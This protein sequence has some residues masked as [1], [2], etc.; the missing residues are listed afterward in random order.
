MGILSTPILGDLLKGVLGVVD[1]LHTSDEEKADIKF[2]ISQLAQSADLAQIAVN[3]EEAK[4]T[5]LFVSGW[6][7]SIG[8]VCSVAF[9]CNFVLFPMLTYVV[10]VIGEFTGRDIDIGQVPQFDLA[11]LMPVLLGML[12]LGTMRTY[13][14]VKGVSRTCLHEDAKPSAASQETPAKKIRKGRSRG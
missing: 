1:D 11:T 6:R 5:K 10:W 2:R 4:S 7:P 14:K 8:W 9:G 13:E 12:G 3:A